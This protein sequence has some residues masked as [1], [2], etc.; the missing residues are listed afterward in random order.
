[1]C[2]KI[3]EDKEKKER[4]KKRMTSAL[5]EIGT[6]SGGGAAVF[7]VV[8]LETALFL[9]L[10]FVLLSRKAHQMFPNGGVLIHPVFLFIVSS[11]MTIMCSILTLMYFPL[12]AAVFAVVLVGM[13][14]IAR[15]VDY[16]HF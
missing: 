8:I 11:M 6:D 9:A 13:I 5:H 2:S 12:S 1:L 7:F 15:R 14:F 10:V 16:G 3:K 4:K